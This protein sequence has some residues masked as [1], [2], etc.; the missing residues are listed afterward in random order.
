MGNAEF[1]S[2]DTNTSMEPSLRKRHV[3]DTHFIRNRNGELHAR[4]WH[5]TP[6]NE[7]SPCRRLPRAPGPHQARA[8]AEPGEVARPS[9]AAV[10]WPR[11]LKVHSAQTT[12]LAP[13]GNAAPDSSPDNDGRC[14]RER[15]RIGRTGSDNSGGSSF[16]TAVMVS[17]GVS[18][19]KARTPE[20]I[21]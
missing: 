13:T 7:P 3:A 19:R 11:F 15:G 2:G 8:G 20:S 1:S 4:R 6:S 10:R 21:S 17:A 12:D 5:G 16:K 9:R 18:R 14:A